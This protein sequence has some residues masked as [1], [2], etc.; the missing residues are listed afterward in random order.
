VALRA[1]VPPPELPEDDG[2]K[3]LDGAAGLEAELAGEF[4]GLVG[5]VVGLTV[6][7]T[8]GATSATAVD[9]VP[10]AVR[11]AVPGAVP[12]GD[13]GELVRLALL[14]L[15]PV[16]VTA[17]ATPPITTTAAAAIS[18][19]VAVPRLRPPP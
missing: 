6:A 5:P 8:G 4:S 11:G 13:D 3:G 7:A 10:G 17:P 2:G 18:A 14:G 16:K 12:L 15:P 1:S 9:G 19:I